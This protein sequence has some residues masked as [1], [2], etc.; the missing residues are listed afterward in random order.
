MCLGPARGKVVAVVG[1]VR[2]PLACRPCTASCRLGSARLGSAPGAAVVV[3]V[4]VVVVSSAS[5]GLL[6]TAAVPVDVL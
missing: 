5:G 6:I 4:V 3:V 1:R 2:S